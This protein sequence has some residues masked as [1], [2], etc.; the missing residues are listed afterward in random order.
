MSSNRGAKRI[1]R[2]FSAS[3]DVKIPITCVPSQTSAEPILRSAISKATHDGNV[4]DVALAHGDEDLEH[5]RRRGD[6]E[7]T[8]RGVLVDRA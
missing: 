8:W 6:D 1:T 5:R 4:P 7:G 2:A 3:V